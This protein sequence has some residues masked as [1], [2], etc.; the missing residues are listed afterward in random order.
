MRRSD[1]IRIEETLCYRLKD[2]MRDKGIGPEDFELAGVCVKTSIEAYLN[3]TRLPTLRTLYRIARYLGVSVDWLCGMDEMNTNTPTVDPRD[4]FYEAL[5]KVNPE[6]YES[7]AP[8]GI[9]Q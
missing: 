2:I 8:W 9:L 7:E 1:D 5:D 6:N 4:K 3:M